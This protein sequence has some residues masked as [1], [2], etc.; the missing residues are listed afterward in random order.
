[1]LKQPVDFQ[2]GQHDGKS[3]F[4]FCTNRIGDIIDVLIEGMPE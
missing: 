4:P 1:M 2:S 3:S